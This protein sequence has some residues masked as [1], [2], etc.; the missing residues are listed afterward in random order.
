MEFYPIGHLRG[1]KKLGIKE[2]E[3]ETPLRKEAFL[4]L[5][6]RNGD[7]FG[8]KSFFL[9]TLPFLNF[10]MNIQER[11]SRGKGLVKFKMIFDAVMGVLYVA[12]G[13]LV[14]GAKSFGFR[15]TV[16][17]SEEILRMLGIVFILYG[18]FRVYRAFKGKS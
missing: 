1:R 3:A 5:K 2:L 14:I 16:P 8:K 10:L 7:F 17:I 18:L 9:L 15:F 13:I 4:N 6:A 11:N 12:V